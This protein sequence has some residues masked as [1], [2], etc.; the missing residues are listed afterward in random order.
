MALVNSG[1]FTGV[2]GVFFAG[3]GLL[4]A[5]FVFGGTSTD[6]YAGANVLDFGFFAGTVTLINE[7]ANDLCYKW[8]SAPNGVDSGV[9]KAG[10]TL[11]FQPTANKRGVSIR[12]R[13]NGS[14]SAFVVAAF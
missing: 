3:N 6:T 11:T 8:P 9:L 7:G 2:S 14:Q 13:T 12:A 4:D 1:A 5:A 10:A